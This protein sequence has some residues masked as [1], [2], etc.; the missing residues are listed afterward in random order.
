MGLGFVNEY[1]AEKA[2]EALHA[3]IHH[4]AVA[5]RDGGAIEVEVTALVPGDVV[6][7]HLG[8]IVPADLRLLEANGIECAES[9]LNGESLPVPKDTAAVATGTALA[10][11]S[12]CA[13]MGTVVQVGSGRGVQAVVHPRPAR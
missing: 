13:L 7:L 9:V 4:Q 3:Q 2:A 12:C 5:L 10:D 8:D 1:R 11:L 6:E